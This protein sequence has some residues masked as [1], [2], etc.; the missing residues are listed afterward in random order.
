MASKQEWMV[1]LPDKKDSLAARMKVRPDHLA[2]LKPSVEAGFWVMGGASLDEPVKE[3]EGPKINGSV[4]IAVAE[5]KEEVLDK[6]K[7]DIYY[8]SG[9]WDVENINIFPFKSAIRSAL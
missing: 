2:A 3:G 7:A 5:S 6:I 9:V 8:K 1:I 4:M